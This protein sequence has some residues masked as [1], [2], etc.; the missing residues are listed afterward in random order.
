MAPE[1]IR[2]NLAIVLPDPVLLSRVRRQTCGYFERTNRDRCFFEL[3]WRDSFS[4]NEAA[5]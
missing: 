5:L 2:M 1:T 4:T 3:L